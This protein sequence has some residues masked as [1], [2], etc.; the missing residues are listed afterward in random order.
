MRGES[1]G[2]EAEDEHGEKGGEGKEGEKHAELL[3]GEV[4]E[5][6]KINGNVKEDG[7]ENAHDAE[8]EEGGEEVFPPEAEIEFP[9][10]IKEEFPH[11]S[12]LKKAA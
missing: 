10:E 2:E 3:F 5:I 11:P 6:H 7:P 9:S 12:G 8:E 1:I 4:L